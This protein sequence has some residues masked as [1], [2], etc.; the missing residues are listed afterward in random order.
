MNLVKV[1]DENQVSILYITGKA[2]WIIGSLTW[3]QSFFNQAYYELNTCCL[4][5]SIR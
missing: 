1:S 4:H 2:F 3:Y 5:T